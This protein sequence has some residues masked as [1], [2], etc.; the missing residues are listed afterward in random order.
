MASANEEYEVTIIDSPPSLLADASVLASSVDGVL[1]VVRL[2][3]TPESALKH[4]VDQ[5]RRVNGKIVGIVI[6]DP[7][8]AYSHGYLGY[9]YGSGRVE[10]GVGNGRGPIRAFVDRLRGRARSTTDPG[11]S[12]EG[13]DSDGH[14]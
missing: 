11:A 7:S 14:S 1:V 4:A 10:P 2:K 9:W 3:H 12:G 8:R 6:N 13:R 5:L